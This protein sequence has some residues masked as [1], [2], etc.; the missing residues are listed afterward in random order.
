MVVVAGLLGSTVRHFRSPAQL[1]SARHGIPK[2]P[3]KQAL[4]GTGADVGSATVRNGR[5]VWPIPARGAQS[6]VVPP[7]GTAQ[8]RRQ[9]PRSVDFS[10]GVWNTQMVFTS[11]VQSAVV[12]QELPRY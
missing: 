5:H 1:P 11:R 12:R 7:C 2:D 6:G 3:G 8:G 10:G 9:V 4:V